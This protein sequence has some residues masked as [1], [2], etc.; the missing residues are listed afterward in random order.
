L[1]AIQPTSGVFRSSV[2]SSRARMSL[3]RGQRTGLNPGVG[4][5]KLVGSKLP[6]PRDRRRA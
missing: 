5:S 6:L 3:L 4:S 1:V 2:V